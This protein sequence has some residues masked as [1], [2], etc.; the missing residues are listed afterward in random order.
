[1]EK[2]FLCLLYVLS[3]RATAPSMGIMWSCLNS[4]KAG[5]KMAGPVS[6]CLTCCS[7]WLIRFLAQ[8][9]LRNSERPERVRT[10]PHSCQGERAFL[11]FGSFLQ[12]MPTLVT[13]IS[14]IPTD[15]PKGFSW[16]ASDMKASGLERDETICMTPYLVKDL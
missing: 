2:A 16:A 10:A 7:C 13:G 15:V 1:M 3:T 8:L 12:R 6:P 14:T 9:L 4:D 11:R 5:E